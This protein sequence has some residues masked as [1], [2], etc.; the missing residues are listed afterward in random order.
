[1]WLFVARL[2][3]GAEMNWLYVVLA[4]PVFLLAVQFICLSSAMFS[5]DLED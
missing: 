1:M 3:S 4:L 5:G 2:F